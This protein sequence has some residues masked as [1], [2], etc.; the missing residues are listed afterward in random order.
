MPRFSVS[1]RATVA[2]TAARGTSL[3]NI[4]SLC[5]PKVVEVGVFNTTATA[6]VAS[7]TR[8]TA[9][10]TQGAGLTETKHDAN[11]P[12]ADATGFACHTADAT[13]SDEIVRASI[14][15]A[16]GGGMVWTFGAGGISIPAGTAN[17][18][19]ILCP[20]GTGQI[21]DYYIVWDE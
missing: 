6:F 21:Y 7:L 11:G 3:Y 18:L 16:I 9:T 15:A 1:G 10:G 2:S 8:L 17:G 19:G 12:A 4:A 14:A 13:A 20:T 5:S